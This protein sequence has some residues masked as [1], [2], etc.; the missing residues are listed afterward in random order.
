MSADDGKAPRRRGPGR[1]PRSGE[2]WPSHRRHGGT[3]VHCRERLRTDAERAVEP[4][5][6]SDEKPR[7]GAPTE[8]PGDALIVVRLSPRVHVHDASRLHVGPARV[9]TLL[10]WRRRRPDDGPD[11]HPHRRVSISTARR[12]VSCGTTR[13]SSP[14]AWDRSPATPSPYRSG[15]SGTGSE[16][17]SSP[18]WRV[19]IGSSYVGHPW[20]SSIISTLPLGAC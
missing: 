15:E 14:Q 7:T 12:S 19:G 13:P 20:L 6:R 5:W 4:T 18:G 9:V 10:A 3:R 2:R 11:G 8:C 17:S 16:P 1:R